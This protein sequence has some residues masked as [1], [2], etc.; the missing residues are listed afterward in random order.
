M[1][2]FDESVMALESKKNFEDIK[3][4]KMMYDAKKSAG[5]NTNYIRANKDKGKAFSFWRY[6]KSKHDKTGRFGAKALKEKDDSIKA[7]GDANLSNGVYFD[8]LGMKTIKEETNENGD[9]NITSGSAD[10]ETFLDT[11]NETEGAVSTIEDDFVSRVGDELLNIRDNDFEAKRN[12]ETAKMAF[13]STIRKRD[14]ENN[15]QTYDAGRAFTP[16]TYEETIPDSFNVRLAVSDPPPLHKQEWEQYKAVNQKGMWSNIKGWF[17]KIFNKPA[18]SEDELLVN[19]AKT[20]PEYKRLESQGKAA[21]SEAGQK[22]DPIADL[23]LQDYLGDIKEK[24]KASSYGHS[25]VSMVAKKSGKTV[26]KY[27]FAFVCN[28][29]S[30]MAGTITGAVANPTG[31]AATDV[32]DDNRVSYANYLRAAAKIRATAGSMRQYSMIGYNCA[33]FAADVGKAAGLSIKDSDTGTN[34]MTH[35]HHSQRVDSPYNLAAYIKRRQKQKGVPTAMTEKEREKS[36]KEFEENTNAKVEEY[37][38]RFMPD[39]MNNP[40]VVTLRQYNLVSDEELS[41]KF[42]GFLTDVVKKCGK[43]D[44]ELP[45]V[46]DENEIKFAQEDRINRRMELFGVPVEDNYISMFCKDEDKILSRFVKDPTNANEVITRFFGESIDLENVESK[47]KNK[48]SFVNSNFAKEYYP[49]VAYETLRKLGEDILEKIGPVQKRMRDNIQVAEGASGA[50]L[51]MEILKQ[52]IGYNPK[53]LGNKIFESTDLVKQFF[54]KEGLK[55]PVAEQFD[56]KGE[57]KED[58]AEKKNEV[59]LTF[60]AANE[61]IGAMDP[62]SVVERFVNTVRETEPIQGRWAQRPL[63]A[64]HLTV[65]FKNV[66]KNKDMS[67]E[68]SVLYEEWQSADNDDEKLK[69][70]EEMIRTIARYPKKNFLISR[71]ELAGIS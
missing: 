62:D 25:S 44:R 11:A 51:L 7:L 71:L 53:M 9:V 6:I 8:P 34:M 61:M 70:F 29:E 55:L 56:D 14:I 16:D 19:F 47:A 36:N 1:G 37:A 67:N 38:N 69:I 2:R 42:K 28:G 58:K 63:K 35:R 46:G 18:P 64:N 24:F 4:L 17:R 60:A 50:K 20:L 32:F 48:Y 3:E 49:G 39:L 22:Y 66:L 57:K 41:N 5:D 15:D 68:L 40:T 65:F 59:R 33:S 13:A 12:D 45:L 31:F 10:D 43:I 52:T 21:A 26:S 27:T 30:G 23:D 54:E